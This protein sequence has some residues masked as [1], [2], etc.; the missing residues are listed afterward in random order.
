MAYTVKLGKDATLT[1]GSNELKLAR[2]ITVDLGGSEVDVT[3]RDSGGF[4]QYV[5]GLKE[6]SISGTAI[7]DPSN[8]A[9]KALLDSWE[10]G[11][12][13]SVTLSDPT[14][15]YS[16]KYVCT[17]ITQPQ[18]L[19]GVMTVDFTLKPTPESTT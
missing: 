10:D 19:D 17:K 7:Y 11:I 13:L 14:F 5:L 6:V 4:K 2:D 16:G 18:P 1:I 12:A 9:V 8:A 15:A 3:C